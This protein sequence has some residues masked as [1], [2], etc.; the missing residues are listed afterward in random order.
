M[1]S[2]KDKSS[3]SINA[4]PSI[5]KKDLPSA[6]FSSKFLEFATTHNAAKQPQPQTAA[7]SSSSKSSINLPRDL[8]KSLSITP[9]TTSV[10][11]S[12]TDII[13][14]TKKM[15]TNQP[16]SSSPS[17]SS[18][19]GGVGGSNRSGDSQQKSQQKDKYIDKIKTTKKSS[20]AYGN[21]TTKEQ[22]AAQKMAAQYN[23]L[24]AEVSL[25]EYS[26]QMMLLAQYTDA[27]NQQS[28]MQQP[29]N[30][31]SKKSTQASGRSG[32]G[33]HKKSTTQSTQAKQRIPA[34]AGSPHG[35]NA[36]TSSRTPPIGGPSSNFMRN[37]PIPML[38]PAHSKSP[39]LGNYGRQSMTPPSTSGTVQSSKGH[40]TRIMEQPK[41]K[42]GGS[43]GSNVGMN[44]SK[45]RNDSPGGGGGQKG[46]DKKRQQPTTSNDVIVLD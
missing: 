33:D 36:S 42:Q 32:G 44:L 46:N 3:A 13:D 6:S 16:L 21:R 43:G 11:G 23:S 9:S 40:Q 31:M 35:S 12:P 28:A 19:T 1:K 26:R 25:Q 20:T 37:S 18:N 7:H 5:L 41:S 38:N 4:L 27:L 15:P 2:S 30:Q 34:A 24:A 22:L 14:M 29:L 45:Q 8:P 17:G 39:L 10:Y